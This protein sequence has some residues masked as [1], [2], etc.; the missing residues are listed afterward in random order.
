M[1]GRDGAASNCNAELPLDVHCGIPQR[2]PVVKRPTPRLG[3]LF[4]SVCRLTRD[5]GLKRRLAEFL[6]VHPSRLSEWI[7]GVCEPGGEVT[8]QLL[9]WVTATK[10]KQKQEADRASTRPAR[11]T[12]NSKVTTNEKAKSDRPEG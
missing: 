8:L 3:K 6:G 11:M 12:R 7:S 2:L 10:A 5:R 4:V 1:S 9:E